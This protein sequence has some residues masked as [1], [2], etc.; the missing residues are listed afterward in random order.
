MGIKQIALV[1]PAIGSAMSLLLDQLKDEGGKRKKEKEIPTVSRISVGGASMT[2]S[3]AT[4]VSLWNGV[5]NV[6][7]KYRTWSMFNGS[8]IEYFPILPLRRNSFR[9]EIIWWLF[10]EGET[11]GAFLVRSFS[12]SAIRGITTDSDKQ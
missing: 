7:G 8:W 12:A 1:G 2:N 4:G 3:E 6:N 9:G 11:L 10:I 5:K